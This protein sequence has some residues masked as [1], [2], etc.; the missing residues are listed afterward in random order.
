MGLIKPRALIVDEGPK[1]VIVD[2]WNA[3]DLY[4]EG[5]IAVHDGEI[6]HVSLYRD[7]LAGD[8]IER[9]IVAV[10][11]IAAARYWANLERAVANEKAARA[12]MH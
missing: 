5:T 9:N 3:I 7:R 8:T 11:H 4:Y 12:L 10:G 1:I 2:G 6:V